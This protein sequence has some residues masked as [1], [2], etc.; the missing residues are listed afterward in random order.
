M[1]ELVGRLGALLLVVKDIDESIAFYTETVG[2]TLSERSEA[3]AYL[4]AGEFLLCLQHHPEM[5]EV[6]QTSFI[7]F[8]VE[9]IDAAHERLLA[10][11]VEFVMPVSPF[12]G[13]NHG[14]SFA[15]PSGHM[16][17][18]MGPKVGE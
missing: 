16:L 4:D 8:R 3:F 18:I 14:T 1:S 7:V 17:T 6:T 5:P 15:D 11:D 9:D 13:E 2:C 12:F 10:K